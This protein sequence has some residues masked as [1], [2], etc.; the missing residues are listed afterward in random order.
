[1]R[2]THARWEETEI[3]L[4]G[5][6][7]LQPTEAASLRTALAAVLGHSSPVRRA[8]VYPLARDRAIVR[9]FLGQGWVPVILERRELVDAA[10]LAVRFARALEAPGKSRTA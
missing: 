4:E 7:S 5:G 6:E 1:V 2:W 10:S 9:L 3:A 8:S